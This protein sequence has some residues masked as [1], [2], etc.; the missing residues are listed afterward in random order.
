M[1]SGLDWQGAVEGSSVSSK[2]S[3]HLPKILLGSV[4]LRGTDPESNMVRPLP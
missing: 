4:V 1:G 2:S 3:S